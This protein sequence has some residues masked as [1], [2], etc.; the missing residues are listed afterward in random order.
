MNTTTLIRPIITEKSL[1]ETNQGW[2]T[3][4]VS[5]DSNKNTIAQAVNEEFKVHV[6]AVKTAIMKGKTK[7][8]GKKRMLTKSSGYKKAY[9]RLKPNEKIA[10]FE[11]QGKAGK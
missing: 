10:L 9:V 1:G 7:R 2:Y 11:T 8:S 3:F 4:V 6:I 5:L